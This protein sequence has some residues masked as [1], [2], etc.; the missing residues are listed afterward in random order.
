MSGLSTSTE[1]GFRSFARDA[2][3]EQYNG[4]IVDHGSLLLRT[5]GRIFAYCNIK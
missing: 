1:V 5:V 2:C 3:K 4:R